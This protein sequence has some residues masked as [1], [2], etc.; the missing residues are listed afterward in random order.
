MPDLLYKTLAEVPEELKAEATQKDGQYVVSVVPK[1]KLDEFRNNNIALSRERD[2]L[3]NKVTTYSSLVGEDPEKAKGELNELR[4]TY[5][6]VKD[7]SLKGSDAI[8]AAVK[9]RIKDTETNYQGQLATLGTKLQEKDASVAALADQ[10][11]RS[12]IDRDVTNAVLAGDSGVNP[13]ALPD[14]LTRAYGTFKVVNGQLVAKSGDAV[15]YGSDGVTPLKPKEWLAKVLKDSPYLGKQSAGGGANGGGNGGEGGDP[16]YGMGK[17]AYDKLLP[18]A[19]LNLY[20]KNK[21]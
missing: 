21:K 19:K 12:L 10:L 3:K 8:E 7:G 4:T 6:R 2:E 11:N 20:R 17:E 13:A 9:E 16:Y 18:A 5:Q 1:T 14:I 15:I